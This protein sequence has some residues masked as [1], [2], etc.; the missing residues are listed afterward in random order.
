MTRIM[1]GKLGPQ[2]VE[3]RTS[4]YQARLYSEQQAQQLAAIPRPN[5]AHVSAHGI[6][7]VRDASGVMR[8]ARLTKEQLMALE[9]EVFEAI[10]RS[11]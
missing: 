2:G 8:A 5:S 10:R 7:T 6:V 3:L 4:T 9:L 1:T 11:A